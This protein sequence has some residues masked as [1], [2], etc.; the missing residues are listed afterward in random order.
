[1]TLY[2]APAP[3]ENQYAVAVLKESRSGQLTVGHVPRAISRLCWRTME[4]Y[5]PRRHSAIPQGGIGKNKHIK[6]LL[7]KNETASSSPVLH[8]LQELQV[9]PDLQ[10]KKNSK[11]A[12]C[13]L[14]TFYLVSATLIN[15]PLVTKQ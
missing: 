6:K 1:M 5:G 2:L 13:S 4:K 9:L 14:I 10:E 8:Q 7:T 3:V 12:G 11:L 15:A